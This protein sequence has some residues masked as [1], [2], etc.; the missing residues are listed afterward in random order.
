[1]AFAAA[2][3]RIAPPARAAAAPT[4]SSAE[5]RRVTLSPDRAVEHVDRLFRVAMM[6]C[7][8]RDE[9]EDLVQETYAQVLARPRTVHADNELGYLVRALRN[10]HLNGLRRR[11]RRVRTAPL[12]EDAP[13]AATHEHE[14][15]AALLRSAL[16]DAIAALAPAYREVLLQ[17]DVA[18]MSYREAAAALGVPEGTIM[19][20]LYR[21]RQA[22]ARQLET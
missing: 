12:A 4:A 8:N 13:V 5:P 16:R 6:I 14:G 22:V 11:Q 7:G 17:V 2:L 21:A 9:A 18:G 19:S 1:M 15:D 3:P 20:R 10:T